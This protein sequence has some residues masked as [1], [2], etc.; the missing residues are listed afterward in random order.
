MR[1]AVK[2]KMQIVKDVVQGRDVHGNWI[3][4]GTGIPWERE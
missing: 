2:P 1:R 3:P 4:V